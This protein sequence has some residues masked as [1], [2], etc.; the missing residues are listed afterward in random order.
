MYSRK[1]LLVFITYSLIQILNGIVFL[2]AVNTFLPIQFGYLQVAISIFAIFSVL[3]TLGFAMTHVKIMAEKEQQNEAFT[4]FFWIKIILC[5]F[6]TIFI[7]FI[8]YIQIHNGQI[9]NN[10]EQIVVLLIVYFQY[11]LEAFSSVFEL[12]F[13][14]KMLVAKIE[15]PLIIVTIIN[16]LLSMI[17]IIVFRNFFLYLGGNVITNFIKLIFYY[18]YRGN[19]R[20]TKICYKLLK[21]YLILNLI[22]FIPELCSTLSK[23]LG[24]LIFLNFYNE[25]LLGIYAVLTSF[26]LMLYGLEDTFRYLLLPNFSDLL[27]KNKKDQLKNLIYLYEKFL[28]ILNALIII[29]GISFSK[30][31]IKFFLGQIYY[32]K[33]LILFYGNLLYIISY[34]LCSAYIS[35]L[36]A[37]VRIKI[38]AWVS[39][40]RFF[41]VAISWFIFI[42]IFNIIGI[43]IGWWF[44]K[45]PETIIIRIYCQ[46]NFNVGKITK[47]ESLHLIVISFL[48]FICFIVISK[49]LSLIYLGIIVSILLISYLLYLFGFKILGKNDINIIR[50][51]INTKE[52]IKYIKDELG[53]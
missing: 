6:S 24:P 22:F 31:I 10:S 30:F 3:S 40:S 18:F 36:Y 43:I 11:L 25:E 47:S 50:D 15:I 21:R 14:A 12:S 8:I 1:S 20:I 7:F 49:D 27:S 28:L 45:I 46:K 48:I 34:P 29:L 17:S 52:V 42:P 37:S 41:F 16:V 13:R 9:S 53:G 23:N 5:F 44:F 39:V 35:L 19:F 38:Y 51:I 4:I 26:F 32:E 2:F 33:G